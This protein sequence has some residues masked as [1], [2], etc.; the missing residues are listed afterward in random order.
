MRLSPSESHCPRVASAPPGLV[1]HKRALREEVRVKAAARGVFP[2]YSR[3]ELGLH[4]EL[5]ASVNPNLFMSLF[6]VLD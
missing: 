6:I 3:D 2:F 1:V 4:G 5:Q